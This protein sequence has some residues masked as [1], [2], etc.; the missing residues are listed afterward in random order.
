[1]LNGYLPK[2]KNGR[3]LIQGILNVTPD[4][5]YDGGKYSSIDSAVA[6]GIK[7]EEQGADIIDVGGESSRP[8]CNPV[9]LEEE[10]KRVLLILL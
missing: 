6:H 1:M 2:P 9:S 10:Q 3:I 8:G 4:S 5:F 7:L